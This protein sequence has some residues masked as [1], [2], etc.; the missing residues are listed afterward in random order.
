[1]PKTVIRSFKFLK[2]ATTGELMQYQ[3]VYELQTDVFMSPRNYEELIASKQDVGDNGDLFVAQRDNM[4]YLWAICPIGEYL[5][6]PV[7]SD[8]QPKCSKCP[9]YQSSSLL[10]PTTCQ[11]CSKLYVNSTKQSATD[12]WGNKQEYLSYTGYIAH[13]LC[14]NRPDLLYKDAGYNLID[15]VIPEPIKQAIKDATGLSEEVV[16]IIII[17]SVGLVCLLL[18]VVGCI[19]YA[20]TRKPKQE[21][22]EVYDPSASQIE[23]PLQLPRDLIDEKAHENRRDQGGG[24]G[25]MAA[26]GYSTGTTKQQRTT[27]QGNDEVEVGGSPRTRKMEARQTERSADNGAISS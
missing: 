7:A 2:N 3:N 20:K 19:Y 10:S 16:L 26:K 23:K 1:M 12:F 11:E 4:P 8:G 13:S 18:A 24:A 25:G 14:H 5:E 15:K 9:Q 22:V 6:V 17:S 21:E 27:T